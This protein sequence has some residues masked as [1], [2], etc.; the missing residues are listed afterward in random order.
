MHVLGVHTGYHDASVCLYKDFELIAAVSLE[1]LKRIKSAG[2]TTRQPMPDEAVDECLEIGGISRGDVDVLCLSR[3]VF[4][5]QDY[6]L[7]GRAAANQLWYRLRRKPRLQLLDSMML[8]EGRH[9]AE[10]VFRS[11]SFLEREGFDRAKI[12][13]YNHHLAHGIAAYFYSGFDEALIHTADGAGDRVS[14]SARVGRLG[15]IETVFGGDEELFWPREANSLGLLYGHFTRAL[16]FIANRHEG[17]LVGLA[18]HGRPIAAEQILSYFSVEETGRIRSVVRT[19]RS[20]A[21][22]VKVI[23]REI[24][25]EDA[26]ASV[27]HALEVLM[28]QSIS[29]LQK[30]TGVNKLA[31][32]GGIY[33]NVRLNRHLLENTPADAVF[34]IP[35]MGDEGLPLGGCLDYLYNHFGFEEWHRNR[36]VLESMLLGRDYRPEP[37]KLADSF[38]ELLLLSEREPDEIAAAAVEAM[39]AGKAVGIY[40]GRMEFGPRALG[41]RSIIASPVRGDI[42]NSL[43]ARLSRSDFMPFAPVVMAEHAADVFDINGG[44]AHP[45]RFMTIT[46]DVKPEWRERIPAAVHVDGS[47]RP[48]I[49]HPEPKT[50]YRRILETWNARTGIPVLVNTSFNVHEEPIIDSPEQALAALAANRVDLLVLGGRIFAR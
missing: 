40:E 23:C 30:R 14:Y 36:R 34:I 31:L 47:A 1:R 50:L 27:Q 12:Y 42:N 16:G 15:Q 44:N 2:V 8:K 17:K 24:S 18:A 48:Q 5:Y 28:T 46:C 39:L 37:E 4:D 6:K 22:E 29:T 45:A 33:A 49:L 3:A 38:P 25:R 11:A 35:A 13:F 20:M 32:G 26:A 10:S 9:D 43:N 21:A 19:N 41:A 7:T